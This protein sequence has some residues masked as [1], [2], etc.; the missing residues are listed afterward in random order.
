MDRLKSPSDLENLRRKIIAKRDPNKPCI[1][2]CM[3]T[4]CRALGSEKVVA[5]FKEEIKKR[6]LE[7]KIEIKETGCLGFCENGPRV[8]IYPD[9]ICYFHVTPDDVPEI[10]EKTL[11]GNEFVD[12]LLYTDPVTGKKIPLMKDIPF[13]KHQTRRI[14]KNC[15]LID[16]TKIEDYIAHDGYKALCKVLTSMT[17]EEVI[18]EIKLSKLRGRGGA[19]FPTGLKWSFAARAPGDVKYV[20]CNADEGDPGAYMDRSIMEGNP[21]LVLEGLTIAAYAIGAHQGFIYIRAEYPLA[22]QIVKRAIEQ[23]RKYGLLGKNIL[24]TGFDFDVEVCLGAGAFVCGEETALIASIEGKR[25]NPRPRPPYPATKGLFGKPTVINNVKTLANVT[26]ICLYGHEWF[27]SVGTEKS[28]GTMIFS[29]TGKIRNT[30]LIEVPL[31]ITLGE[32]IFDI[33]G[34]VPNGKKFKAVQT[35]GPSGGCIPSKYLNTPV[36]YEELKALGSI[37]GSGG[38]IVMDEDSC[39][40]DMARFFMEFTKNESCGKCTPCRAGIPRMLEILEKISCGEGELKDLEELESLALMVKD[41]SLCGLGQTAP[42][43]VL[44]TLRHFKDEY[45]AH[46]IDKKCPAAVCQALFKSPCQHTCPLGTNIPGYISLIAAGRYKEAYL[47]IRQSNPLPTVC[48]RVCHHPCEFKCRR[49]QIDEPLAINHLKRFVTDYALEN[50]I[51][52]V[53]NISDKKEGRV[54]IIGAGPAGLSAAYDLAINGYNVTI[55]E[56]LPVVGGML[57]VGIPEYRLPR[58]CIEADTAVLRKMGVEIKLNTKIDDISALLKE[59]YDAVFVATGAHLG[60]RM[61][62]PGEDL[63]GVYDGVEF[64]RKVNLGEEVDVG[65]V[66]AVIG[67]GNVAIDSARVSMRLGAEKVYI[68]YRRRK[69][70]MPAI[71]EEVEAAEEEGV[72]LH[73]LT[74]PVRILGEDSKVSAIECARMELREF[75]ETGRKRPYKIEGS[76]FTIKVDTV[77]EAIG[78]RADTSFL[79]G[80]VKTDRRGLIVTDERTLET[81]IPGVFAGGDVVTGPK[82]VVEAIAAGQRGAFSIMCYLEGKPIPKRMTR[83]QELEIP[84]PEGTVEEEIVEKPRVPLR[85]R[86]PET[87]K[88]CFEE[89][90]LSYSEEEARREAERCL[91]CDLEVMEE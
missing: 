4:G 83:K 81:N 75:D 68:I 14:L 35:G 53:P 41:C 91:R 55:Y 84:I 61:G 30:G 49:N 5:V 46:I 73:T 32:I 71:R 34:G 24:G 42:N 80:L 1:S 44:S 29:L 38:M 40:I 65:K 43:P 2:I 39:M 33:G 6:G 3:G 76:E 13:F 63:K 78:Q 12:R 7:D 51:D 28:K 21:H 85:F 9:E 87:R 79:K 17:P 70:D 86:P 59:G 64:L 10:I 36:D 89:V 82:S 72:I 47:L 48:G 88:T 8:V 19:G 25:G 37:M 57:A 77:I 50:G 67:G 31:G 15:G 18:N 90:V 16:P 54:A 56:A 58:K 74:N 22:V 62:I 66:V 27:A 23:S 69:E 45:I 60:R 11:I 20:I 52:Y 26:L